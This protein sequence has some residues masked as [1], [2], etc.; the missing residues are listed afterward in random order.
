MNKEYDLTIQEASE[1]LGVSES[2]IRRLIKRGQL[3]KEYEKA[4]RGKRLKLSSAEIDQMLSHR[5]R[6]SKREDLISYDA[7]QE[8]R[9]EHEELK[10]RYEAVVYRLGAVEARYKELE[11]EA[12]SLRSRKGLW[13]R[14]KDWL[15]G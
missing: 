9:R 3:T 6:V 8:L 4:K 10:I 2:T 7:Y 15:K 11:I 13:E 1:R 5:D 14:I 12:G